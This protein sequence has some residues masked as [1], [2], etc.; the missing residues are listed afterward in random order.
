MEQFE[1]HD[2][3]DDDGQL[4]DRG[5]SREQILQFSLRDIDELYLM[6]HLVVSATDNK[7]REEEITKKQQHNYGDPNEGGPRPPKEDEYPDDED[8]DKDDLLSEVSDPN[9]NN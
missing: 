2:A 3:Y 4:L 9:E 8:E 6:E 5:Y 7:E 1:R